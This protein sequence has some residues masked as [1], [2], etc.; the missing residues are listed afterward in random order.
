MA[1]ALQHRSWKLF[2]QYFSGALSTPPGP[3]YGGNPASAATKGSIDSELDMSFAVCQDLPV[4]E[5]QSDEKQM[6]TPQP[7]SPVIDN[8]NA[9]KVMQATILELQQQLTAKEWL[10]LQLQVCCTTTS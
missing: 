1:E 5:E 9:G 7:P 10:L 3:L 6:S 4:A 8:S 2:N